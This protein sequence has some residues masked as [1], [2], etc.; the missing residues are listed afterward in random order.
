MLS[1]MRKHAASWMI[2]VII[3]AITI[4]F[5]FWGV[6]GFQERKKNNI[7]QVNEDPITA[8][9]Y[10]QAYEQLIQRLQQNFGRNLNEEI[11]KMLN[12]RQQAMRQVIEDKL[13]L[14][15]AK[16]L[17]LKVTDEELAA[18]IADISYFKTNG[19]FDARLYN[20]LLSRNR[21]TPEQF[22][23][24][25]RDGLLKDRVRG[26]IAAG[27]KV[28]KQ[29]ARE[30]YNW[31]NSQVDVNFVIFRPASQ[32]NISV[33]DDE[34]KAFFDKNKKD[35]ETEPQIKVRYLHFN[36]SNY[37]DQ[38]KISKDQIKAFYEANSERF[39][40]PET[41][42]ARHILFKV[43]QDAS[44]ELVAE[45]RKQA[46][47]I[48]AQ[49]RAGADFAELAKKYSDGPTKDKGGYLGTFARKNMVKPFADKAFAMKAG[50]ISD[51]VRTQFGWHVIKV[52]KKNPATDKKL[53]EVENEIR[54]ELIDEEA[55]NLAYD[56][57][58]AVFE[59]AFQGD[60]LVQAAEANGY[61]L[62]TTDFFT[63]SKP[64]KGLPNPTKFVEAAF[65]LTEMEIS[66]I[67]DF[68]DG[69]YLLQ[70]IK[71]IPA[72]IPAFKSVADQVQKDLIEK[73]KDD[74]AKAAAKLFLEK[75]KKGQIWS[76]LAKKA[77]VETRTTGWFKRNAEVPKIGYEQAI[78]DAA[79]KLSD[80]NKYPDDVLMG[81]KGYYVLAF[82]GRKP[83]Q[84]DGF[85]AQKDAIM[86]RLR[87][88]KQQVILQNWFKSVKNKSTIHYEESFLD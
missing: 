20:N 27:A 23:T 65:K 25:Q 7:G 12:V 43:S 52:E 42:E 85:D 29:E 40:I 61:T 10:R 45:K 19:T 16:K 34:V 47:K 68:G 1:T 21:L 88:Q 78:A 33:S 50:E 36:P 71:T 76:D 77:G 81:P 87:Q 64:A 58:E 86:E 80:K 44:E 11:I 31:Q 75:V 67:L 28:S 60:D 35:Y 49:A 8:D 53:T 30:W 83:P 66:E 37:K 3:G 69:Y 5:I 13:L 82:K 74:A 51:P 6:G 72:Q 54:T 46:Q 62:H 24:I 73:K 4:V 9:E 55:N 41:V 39:K 17:K 38:V 32:K 70:V 57:V 18:A 14:Q 26:I 15:E 2:K 59:V 22:E 48:A 63:Q 56:E 84:A 79:F